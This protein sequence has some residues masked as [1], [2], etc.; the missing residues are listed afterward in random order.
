MHLTNNHLKASADVADERRF[1][2]LICE[3]QRHLRIK[4]RIV[5]ERHNPI[6]LATVS[7]LRGECSKC[8]S[9]EIRI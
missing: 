2:S 7:L 5:Y 3:N 4:I 6:K 8:S 1:N 9:L